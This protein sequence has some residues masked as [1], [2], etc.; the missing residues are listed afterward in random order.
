M[1]TY[2]LVIPYSCPSFCNFLMFKIS[3]IKVI[4]YIDRICQENKSGD[5]MEFLSRI[6]SVFHRILI[7]KK[8]SPLTQYSLFKDHKDLF[9][10]LHT[11]A[12]FN[13]RRYKG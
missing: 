7:V 8:K 12:E 11:L 10:V 2:V 5:F 6:F 4:V 9:K 13:S 3:D 1:P